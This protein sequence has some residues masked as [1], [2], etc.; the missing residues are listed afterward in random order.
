MNAMTVGQVA[1]HTGVGIET[2]RF[3]ERKALLPVPERNRSGYR[4]YQQAAV[5]R[6]LFIRNAK[7]LG[8][9]LAEIKELLFL[10]VD[11]AASCFEIKEIAVDKI[12]DIE[13][14]IEALTR[15]RDALQEL[16][17]TCRKGRSAAECRILESLLAGDY[18]DSKG[19]K[20]WPGKGNVT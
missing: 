9:S 20:K 8:F 13:Q 16:A 11:D 5:D 14:R 17:R 12:S 6:I 10:R 4:V 19:S 7:A 15:I 18:T 1:R 3:Y 2:V